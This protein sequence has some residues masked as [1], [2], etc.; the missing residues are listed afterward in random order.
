MTVETASVAGGDPI[1]SARGRQ[2]AP[3]LAVVI[4]CYRAASTLAAVIAGIGE[5]VARI[6][7]VDDGCPEGSGAVAEA[8]SDPRVA[9]LRNA[10]N[11]GVGG[12]MKAGYRRARADGA[13]I[14]VK[15]DAD[16]QMDP[17]LLP[18]LVAPLLSRSADYAKG[19]RFAARQLMPEA[20]AGR[21]M[22]TRRRIAN[23]LA[24]FAHKAVTG[25]WGIVDPANGF[26]AIHGA[27]LQ[28]LDLD[29]LADDYLFETDM[30]FQLNL[31]DA[32]VTDVPLPASY[33]SEASSLR[34]GR[35]AARFP[36]FALGRLAQRIWRKYFVEDFNLGSLHLVVGLPLLLFGIL[37]GLF[38]WAE[39]LE[40]GVPATAGT[41]MF[42]ALPIIIGFQL[43]LSAVGYDVARRY[44]S[45]LSRRGE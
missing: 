14:V 45:P 23:N 44:D 24:S 18:R 16:G 1:A 8:L 2:S 10:A 43:L 13:Q 32:V 28:A 11:R 37:L 30:L 5:E 31:R 9:V 41:V 3:R 36:R 6:Y 19:N 34:I 40:T 33:G 21:G 20:V 12:A 17:A 15:I 29:A 25:Y 38:H 39:A 22:P 35:L 27:A 26:T 4:P 42:A 7:V